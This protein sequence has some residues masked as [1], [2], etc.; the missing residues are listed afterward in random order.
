MCAPDSRP[1]AEPVVAADA[2]GF[3]R[4]EILRSGLPVTIRALRPDDRERIAAAFR[5]L[6]RE[7]IYT[8]LFSYRSE[9]TEADLDRIVNVDPGREVALLV[10]IGAGDNEVVIGSGRCV[11]GGA[12]GTAEVA[13]MVEEDYHGLGIASRLLAHLADIARA[14]GIATLEADVLADN[15]A[16]LSVFARSRL[17]MKQRRDGGVMHVKLDLRP[18]AA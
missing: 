10:T 14:R 7:S 2:D 12:P 5:K 11:A 1:A 9:L 15:A 13:F 17:P 4:R 6:D 8:R 16:M 3:V 18:A